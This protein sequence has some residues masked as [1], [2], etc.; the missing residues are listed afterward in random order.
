MGTPLAPVV[1]N[2]YLAILE[3][4]FKKK[5]QN[6]SHPNTEW[7]EFFRDTLMMP[8]SSVLFLNGRLIILLTNSTKWFLP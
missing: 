3:K 6:E 2:I 7:P 1:A 5:C 8:S 4:E